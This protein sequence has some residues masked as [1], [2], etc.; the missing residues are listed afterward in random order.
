MVPTFITKP[1]FCSLRS[2]AR[3]A[4]VEQEHV[5]ASYASANPLLS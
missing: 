3:R 4:A 2:V 5:A 1:L